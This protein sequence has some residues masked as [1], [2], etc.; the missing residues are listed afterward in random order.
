ML[1]LEFNGH[2]N[3]YLKRLR[4]AY[5]IHVTISAFESIPFL[6]VISR[7]FVDTDKFG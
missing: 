6:G 1:V 7:R 4:Q 2:D 3:R 5:G